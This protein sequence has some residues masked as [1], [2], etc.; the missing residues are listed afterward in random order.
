MVQ[1][2]RELPLDEPEH[3]LEARA[4]SYFAAV[5][6]IVSISIHSKFVGLSQDR[7]A[8]ELT[9]FVRVLTAGIAAEAAG[10]TAGPQASRA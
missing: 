6:G 7:L 2:L 8:A 1:A 4:R 5:H 3:A 9:S 10:R